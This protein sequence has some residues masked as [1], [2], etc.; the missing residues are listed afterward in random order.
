MFADI[1]AF[2]IIRVHKKHEPFF[3]NKLTF[4][5]IFTVVIPSRLGNSAE[6]VA[7]A[8]AELEDG[9]IQA[10]SRKKVRIT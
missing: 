6:Q 8:I 9:R 1:G 4:I 7:R 10:V 2:T 5:Y 3:I